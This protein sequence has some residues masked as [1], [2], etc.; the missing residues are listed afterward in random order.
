[1][2][3]APVGHWT[4]DE[5]ETYRVHCALFR[6]REHR[7]PRPAL[8]RRRPRWASSRPSTGWSERRTSR[9]GTWRVRSVP[10]CNRQDAI[11]NGACGYRALRSRGP[12][13]SRR[14]QEGRKVTLRY[15]DVATWLRRIYTDY[16]LQVTSNWLH[17]FADPVVGVHRAC[18]SR[19]IRQG[20]VFV[21]GSGW[22]SP[23]TDKL[24]DDASVEPGPKRRAE[25][26]AV[27]HARSS[28][29]RAHV[30][31]RRGD[32]ARPNRRVRSDRGAVHASSPPLHTRAPRRGAGEGVGHPGFRARG[33]CRR[34]LREAR[35]G[36]GDS[37]DMAR[38]E[39][40][41]RQRAEARKGAGLKTR[42]SVGS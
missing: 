34:R 18:H 8:A 38:R 39:F 33:R 27:H 9:S 31:Q 2:W 15:E 30:R 3:R 29:G 12:R 5:V 11:A 36:L 24:M 13:G 14:R 1:M 10:H 42:R 22:S 41:H 32:A 4:D 17:G 20:T 26:Y 16:D 40:G 6:S 35:Y 37:H 25:L 19:S 23:E 21:D 28:R 7:L